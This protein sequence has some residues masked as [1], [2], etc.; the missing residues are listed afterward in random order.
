MPK[1]P[2][3]LSGSSQSDSPSESDGKVVVSETVAIP[4]DTKQA[5]HASEGGVYAAGGN[6]R[7]YEPIPEYEGLHRWDPA[8]EWTEKEEKKLVR[9][10]SPSPSLC[11]DPRF[12]KKEK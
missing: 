1:S 6:S 12:A 10:V 8:A 4:A 7:Y 9:K 11:A 3:T 2:S 5:A